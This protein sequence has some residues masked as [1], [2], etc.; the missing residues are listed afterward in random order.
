MKK[1]IIYQTDY[2]LRVLLAQG[3][4]LIEIQRFQSISN[5]EAEFA[6]YLKHD[7]KTPISWLVDTTQEEY[8]TV[9]I[10]HVLGKDRRDLMNH[11]RKR[12]FEHAIY[13]YGVV[14]GREAEGRRDDRVLFTALSNPSFLQPWLDLIASYKVPLVGIYSMPLLSQ[15][16]LKYLP[17]APYTLLVGHTPQISSLSPAGL[18]QS[19]FINQKLQFSR[20][21]PLDTKNPQEYANY[22]LKQIVATHHF[23]DNTQI[24]PETK[25][26]EPVSVIILTDTH[27]LDVLKQSISKAP[28][29]LNILILDNL[30]LVQKIGWKIVFEGK[31]EVEGWYLHNFVST[32]LS[33]DLFAK[34]HYAKTV[35]RRYFFYR[36]LRMALYFT[37][38][39][40]FS[41]MATAGGFILK[42]ASV[43]K[44]KGQDIKER[45]EKRQ[46]EL[47]VLRLQ[48][49]HNLPYDKVE[50]IRSVVEIG[51]HLK[52]QHLSPKRAWQKLSQV[53]NQHTYLFLERLEWGI[54]YKKTD[55]F[56]SVAGKVQQEHFDETDETIE[57]KSPLEEIE[58]AKNFIEGMRLHGK[59]HPFPGN[60]QQFLEI[61][62]RFVNDIEKNTAFWL[63]DILKTPYDPNQA[64][65]GKIGSQDQVSKAP[66]VIDILIKHSYAEK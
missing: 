18:R 21:I 60:P 33:P 23:L 37:S 6:A 59:I 31:N 48:Q 61:F 45:T 8:Q 5:G 14:Q 36:R 55:I 16:L 28:A 49:P 12:M 19:F 20:L 29:E 24:L 11:K 57:S 9:L 32:Q 27:L 34:N 10:P 51:I 42:E 2:E 13:N 25:R 54:G 39:L 58:P 56:Q 66:F 1:R 22:V 64:F 50:I 30:D 41:G 4:T 26:T 47:V 17:K 63:V 35:D 62:E 44:Q 40:L 52:A 65:Q 7:P 38:A 43:I 53:L 15:C 46:A 3:K